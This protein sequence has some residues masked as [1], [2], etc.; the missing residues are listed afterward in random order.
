MSDLADALAYLHAQRPLLIHRDV[1][2]GGA[3]GG[4]GCVSGVMG[5]GEQG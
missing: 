4:G 5:G 1:K 2:V 3:M